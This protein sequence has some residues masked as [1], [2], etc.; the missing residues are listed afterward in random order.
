MWYDM[1]WYDIWYDM[2][3]YDMIWY[4]M[5]WY[6]MIWCDVMW[7]DIMWYDMMWCDVICYDVMWCDT[8]RY[9]LWYDMMWYDTI[10]HVMIWYDII[11]MICDMIY[12]L[13]YPQ[14]VRNPILCALAACTCTEFRIW[15]DNGSVHRNMSP[16]FSYWLPTYFVLL[17][18]WIAVFSLWLTPKQRHFTKHK[19]VPH[20]L[21]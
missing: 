13:Y 7:Y 14:I 15:P 21:K 4:D 12:M 10:R 1:M 18:E 19:L 17:T 16:K 3:W 9:M 6:D 11:Y 5:L 2:I 8:I 20:S